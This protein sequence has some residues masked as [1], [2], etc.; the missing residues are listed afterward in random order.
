MIASREVI[1]ILERNGF[2][3][4]SQKGSH[5]KYVK[6]NRTVIVPHPKPQLPLGTFLSIVRQSGLDK[7]DFGN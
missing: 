7:K 3:L 5:C 4:K 2:V 1:R 6:E